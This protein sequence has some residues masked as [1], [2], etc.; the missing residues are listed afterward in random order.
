MSNIKYVIRHNDFAYNDEWY[1]TSEVTLGAIKAV[2]ADQAEADQAYKELVVNALYENQMDNYCVGNGYLSNTQYQALNAFVLEK[3]STKFNNHANIPKFNFDDAF[4]FAKLSEL[5]HYQLLEIDDIKTYYVIWLN[6][7][8]KYFANGLSSQNENFVGIGW[9]DKQYSWLFE[10][11]FEDIIN[12]PIHSLTDSPILL[13]QFLNNASAIYYDK[14]QKMVT[15]VHF[16]ELEFSELKAFN[17]L[18]KQPI[19]EIRQI[20][21]EELAELE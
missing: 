13:E 19:F 12:Q 2:Y 3:T 11:E 18:L 4:E 7:R 10:Y 1:M 8:Q 9:S 15:G 20:S 14:D 17:A 16:S 21:L 5:I 6:K